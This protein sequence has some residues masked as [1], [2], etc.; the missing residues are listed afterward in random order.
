MFDYNEAEMIIEL[1]KDRIKPGL[2]IAFGSVANRTAG[3]NSD[4]DLI[5][6]KESH[7]NRL[8]CSAKARLA[9]EDS[10]IR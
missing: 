8:I 3:D 1:A 6:V 5:L 7:E 10:N 9:L 4:L 2:M